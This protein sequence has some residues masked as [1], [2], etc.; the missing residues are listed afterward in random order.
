[1]CEMQYNQ[2]TDLHDTDT[3]PNSHFCFVHSHS[4]SAK[5]NPL[6]HCCPTAP[7]NAK[8]D[9]VCPV[10]R[11]K[12]NV[13]CPIDAT[14]NESDT[15][16]TTE[17]YN[18]MYNKVRKEKL[19]CPKACNRVNSFAVNGKCYSTI[20]LHQRCEVDAQCHRKAHCKADTKGFPISVQTY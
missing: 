1:M 14:S 5:G 9:P 15:C 6:G 10:G 3:C 11:V 2:L 8:S 19:C 4:Q 16:S 18:C 12:P 20:P 7:S 13:T 17:N